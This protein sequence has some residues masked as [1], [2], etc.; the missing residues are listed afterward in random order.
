VSKVAVTPD[1]SIVIVNWNGGELLARCLDSLRPRGELAAEVIVIDNASSDGSAALGTWPG[2]EIQLI[3]NGENVGFARACNQGIRRGGGRYVLLLNPDA[4]LVAG[5]LEALVAFMDAHPEAGAA[6]PTLLNPDGS[7]QPSGGQLP[8]LRR[9]L[10]IHPLLVR[11]LRVPDDRLRRRDF[12]HVAA[13]EEAS[14]ACLIVRRAA[15]DAVG[16][17]DERFFLYYEDVDWCRR[18][19]EHGWKIYYVPQ[20]RVV[21]H[22]RS[23]TAPRPDGPV[24]HHRSQLW[25]VRK[26]FGPGAWLSLRALSLAVYGG[27]L[28]AAAARAAL[29][30]VPVRRDAVRRYRALLGAALSG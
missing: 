22:W 10:A 1:V 4:R 5:A 19:G 15:V 28:V 29:R 25:Y 30:P 12:G 13:V 20:A 11:A 27:L 17:L 2:G 9:L 26:H 16:L 7:L 23:K 8:G 18:L 3:L 21:H 24:H 6:G 14:G